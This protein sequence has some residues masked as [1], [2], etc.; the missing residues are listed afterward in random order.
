MK[1]ALLRLANALIAPAGVQL[2]RRGCDMR[3]VLKDMS[4]WSKAPATIF[5]LGA[6]KGDWSRMA[7]NFFPRARVIAVDPLEERASSLER[8]KRA[9]GRFEYVVAVAGPT[10]NG[11]VDLAVTPDLDGSTVDGAEG[12][13]RSVPVRSI[14]GM[15]AQ[16][17]LEGPFFLKFDTHG[18]ERP[19]LEGAAETLRQTEFIVME[20]YNFRHTAKTMLFHEM[21]AYMDSL[22][23]RVFNLVDIL[24]RPH[25]H[26]LWQIDLF[27]AR[28]NN[29]IFDSES[30]LGS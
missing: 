21:I 30:F 8:L 23:F 5:D 12:E 14:D 7:L 3:S 13:V 25:D 15:V 10:D 9:D 20:A 1:W 6:A 28:K 16:L 11:S 17:G 2:Y 26:A 18:F 24:Q 19:I 29:P 4:R 22:G 27:F